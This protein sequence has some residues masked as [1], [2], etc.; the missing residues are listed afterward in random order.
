M[1]LLTNLRLRPKLIALF[2]LIGLL[3]VLTVNTFTYITTDNMLRKEI[4]SK[5]D[6]FTGEKQ[7]LLET[8]FDNQQKTVGI[9]ASVQ[10]I[11][12]NLNLYY[13]FRGGAEWEYQ[14]QTV[15]S[16]LLQKVKTENN[17]RDLF[18]VNDQGEIISATNDRLLNGNL[19][20]RDYIKRSL[21][22]QVT[23]SEIFY[24]DLAQ[25]NIIVISA[26]IYNDY[27]NGAL[28]GALGAYFDSNQI[29]EMLLE[30]LPNIGETADS[31]F[32]ND[33]AQLLTLP[34]SSPGMEILK[35]R[36][37]DEGTNALTAALRR[38]DQNFEQDLIFRNYLDNQVLS[39]LK[40]VK[41]GDYP[42]GMAITINYDEV[43]S[44]V[45]T[46]KYILAGLACFV[47]LVVVIFGFS[48]ADSLA[49][50]IIR[51]SEGMREIAEG[52]LTVQIGNN[53]SD[54]LGDLV[55]EQNKMVKQTGALVVQIADSSGRVNQA[56]H[57][58]ATGTQDLSQRTQEQA[59]TLEETAATIEVMN[60]SI[61]HVAN[62][63]KQAD[64]LSQTTHQIVMDGKQSVQETIEAM[65]DISASSKQIA[66]IIK[67][68]ND[69]A[70]QTNLLALNAA[71]EAARAGEQ[72]RG[73]AVVAA[74]V[75]NLAGRA[76]GS[77]KEIENL[78]NE[79]V[80]RVEK[81]DQLVKQS[82]EMLEEIVA[83]GKKTSDVIVEVASAL[84]EQSS[85]SQ[86]IQ[87][88]IYQL[89][90]VTQQNA[91]M[92]EELTS[93]CESLNAEAENLRHLVDT[94]K[95]DDNSRGL[96]KTSARNPLSPTAKV[97]GTSV[98]MNNRFIEDRIDHF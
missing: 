55:I 18:I 59:A 43:F 33:S 31:F 67:V 64:Q 62:N 87:A 94:F 78:I 6:V 51:V 32:V 23:T 48:F 68:V 95:L 27:V 80:N 7:H 42:V 88:S 85:S 69:I 17:Y 26:P 21:D 4:G 77:A 65:A 75:R 70:F 56:S 63:S 45:Q 57:E 29:S 24:S 19:K 8:W 12:S 5:F 98:Q 91:A 10:D 89:N 79:S 49:K 38:G 36:I 53:R 84:R 44:S 37:E 54:E 40:V 86:Q 1:K 3:P 72:G 30:G 34:K 15:V 82:A 46:L 9:I 47:G 14:N 83:N 58:I 13:Y 90:Q 52:N 76:A 22:G 93:S 28:I 60:S 35:T 97:T 50:P 20:D 41:L 92:V 25:S 66:E 81:G 73:F 96:T 11:Y 74:E 71:V 39:N 61:Q 16:A 2:L